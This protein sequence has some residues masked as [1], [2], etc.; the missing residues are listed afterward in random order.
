MSELLPNEILI[1]EHIYAQICIHHEMVELIKGKHEFVKYTRAD[2]WLPISEAPD[3]Q[4]VLLWSPDFVDED[5]NPDGVIFGYK[6]FGEDTWYG[7]IWN[8]EQDCW[9]DREVKP[10]KFMY[11]PQPPKKE[12][13]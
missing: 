4:E 8:G 6:N 12:G 9:D 2:G 13:E 5:F 10:I 1:C 11:K 3:N 7:A